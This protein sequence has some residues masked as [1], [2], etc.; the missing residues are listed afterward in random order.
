MPAVLTVVGPCGRSL[1]LAWR[2]PSHDGG[3]PV[4]LHEL[5]MRPCGAAA[6]ATGVPDEWL[7]MYQVCAS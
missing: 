6:L 1:R 3:A 7:L 4:L 2:P 5:Q